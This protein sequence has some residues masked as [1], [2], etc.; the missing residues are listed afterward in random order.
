MVALLEY[1]K[2]EL[3]APNSV[4]KMEIKW[5]GCS[6]FRSVGCLAAWK[7]V[8]LAERKVSKTVEP[9]VETKDN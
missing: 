1:W 6:D 4:G 8:N 7:V 5:G 3:L 2:V 9:R